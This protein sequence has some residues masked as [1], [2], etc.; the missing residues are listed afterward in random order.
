MACDGY[1][2][3]HALVY[4]GGSIASWRSVKDIR[5][6]AARRHLSS[7]LDSIAG[8]PTSALLTSCNLF[9]KSR[10]H[11]PPAK[12]VWLDRS[13]RTYVN[14]YDAFLDHVTPSPGGA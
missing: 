2:H 3:N 12:I 9:D 7:K 10:P 13:G 5:V 8:L 4:G 1:A 6:E 14:A 11:G